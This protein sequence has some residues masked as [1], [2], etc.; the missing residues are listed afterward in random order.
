[1][2]YLDRILELLESWRITVGDIGGHVVDEGQATRRLA[3]T[4]RGEV[5]VEEALIATVKAALRDGEG[6][7]VRVG[8]HRRRKD[9]DTRVEAVWPADVGGGR[10]LFALEELVNVGE[11]EAVGVK[12]DALAVADQAPAVNLGEGDTEFGSFEQVQVDDIVAI[13][14]I[15]YFDV[16]EDASDL[17]LQALGDRVCNQYCEHSVRVDIAKGLS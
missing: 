14:D 13:H 16:V 12:E 1:M 15:N 7:Y 8:L 6:E 4:P 11:H 5:R 10:K 9:E 3:R 2:H 17:F